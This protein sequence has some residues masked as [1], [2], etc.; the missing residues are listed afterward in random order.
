[1]VWFFI[2]YVIKRELNKT[3]NPHLSKKIS[4]LFTFGQIQQNSTK[5][6]KIQ[7]N[8]T[9][10]NKIL[11]KILAKIILAKIGQNSK[12][13]KFNKIQKNPNINLQNYKNTVVIF[14]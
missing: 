11:A 2:F 8:S 9:K 13:F 14:W 5:F 1:M 3:T 7:Q 4:S 10:F 6:N 12:K